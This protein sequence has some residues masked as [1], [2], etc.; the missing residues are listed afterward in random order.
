[1]T[2][3]LSK[4]KEISFNGDVILDERTEPSDYEHLVVVEADFVYENGNERKD[5]VVNSD[6]WLSEKGLLERL[7][8]EI[9]DVAYV[10]ALEKVQISNYRLRNMDIKEAQDRELISKVSVIQLD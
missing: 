3:K 2:E 8:G 9:A 6:W 5:V 4:S 7:V 10:S 1:M